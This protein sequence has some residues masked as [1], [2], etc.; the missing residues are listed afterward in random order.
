MFSA[1]RIASSSSYCFFLPFAL[2]KRFSRSSFCVFV[3]D[4]ASFAKESKATTC[5]VSALASS[6]LAFCETA[7]ALNAAAEEEAEEASCTKFTANGESSFN[8]SIASS[9]LFIASFAE[10]IPFI[11]NSA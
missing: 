3:Y 7:S 9:I 10:S 5:F 4:I 2:V 8:F 11:D 6:T 1:L